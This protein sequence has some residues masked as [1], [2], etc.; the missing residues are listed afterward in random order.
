M[1]DVSSWY[2]LRRTDSLCVACATSF[3]IMRSNRRNSNGLKSDTRSRP[4]AASKSDARTWHKLL[5]INLRRIRADRHITLE[6]LVRKTGYTLEFVKKV[7]KGER[8]RLL[9]AD[10][11]VFAKALGVK[12]S[13]LVT[14]RRSKDA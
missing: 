7:E 10:A 5:A 1:A 11:E 3:E 6:T 9:L 13:F 2:I 14:R 8:R 4:A 12:V